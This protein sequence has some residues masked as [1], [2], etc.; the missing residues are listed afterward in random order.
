MYGCILKA[1]NNIPLYYCYEIIYDNPKLAKSD[2]K[3]YYYQS[4]TFNFEN[5]ETLESLYELL[6]NNHIVRIG[7]I[8]TLNDDDDNYY[9]FAPKFI[10]IM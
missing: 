1:K 9:F 7:D 10:K 2:I 6:A 3:K 8:I 5:C 4:S